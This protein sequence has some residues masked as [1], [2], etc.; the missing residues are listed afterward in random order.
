MTGTG[1]AILANRISYFYNLH[2]TSVTVDTACSSSLVCL[3]LGNQ[4]LKTGESDISIIVGSSLHFDPREYILMTDLGMLSMDGRSRAF[5]AGA[6]GYV[7]GEGICAAI[8]KRQS[9]AVRNGDHIRAI[10][11]ATGTNHDGRTQGITLPSPEAQEALIRSTYEQAGLKFEDTQY[12]EAHGTGTGAGDPRETSAI[13]AVFAATR[14]QPL[15]VGSV[16]T[17]I[18]H[19]EGSSGLAGIIKTTLALENHKI[20]P[21]ML[22]NN[23]NPKIK[24]EDWK[25]SVPTELIPWEAKNGVR[26]ASINSFGYG[27]TNAHVVLEGYH[28]HQNEDFQFGTTEEEVTDD[29]KLNGSRPYLIPLSSHATKA[30]EK[31]EKAL[32]D[33]LANND[34]IKPLDLAHSLSLRRSI[35]EQRSF[36]IGKNC[37]DLMDQ[38]AVYRPTAPWTSAN[39]TAPRLGFIFTGQGGQWY[40]MGRQLINDCAFFRQTLERCDAVLQALPDA[41]RWS[42]VAELCKSKEASLLGETEYSQPLCTALQLAIVDLLKIW[43]IEP[44]AVVGHSSGEMG[45]AY[46]AGILSFDN[47]LIAAYYRGLYM[48]APVDNSTKGGM[49]AIGLTEPEAVVELEP[50]KGRLAIAAINSPS[51]MTISGDEDAILELKAILT[52]RK[53]FARQLQVTQAF[54]SHHMY[55]LAPAYE[56]ALRSLPGFEPQPPKNIMVSS[57]TGQVA[58]YQT[59]DASYW[60]RNMTNMVKFSEALTKVLDDANGGIDALIEIGPHPALKGPSRQTVQSLKIEKPYFASLTRGVPDYEGILA[61]AGQLFSIGYPVD[62]DA[63]NQEFSILAD[64]RVSKTQKGKR[65]SDLPSYAWEHRRYWAETRYTKELRLRESRHNLLGAP[66]PGSL[67]NHKRWRNRI[68]L[69]EIPWLSEHVVDGKVIFPGAGYISMAI[70][71]A[72]QMQPVSD[73]KA[74][75]LKDIVIKAALVLPESDKGVEMVVE[76][77]PVTTSAKTRSSRWFEFL[78]CSYDVEDRC[79]EHCHGLISV[80]QGPA[81]LDVITSYPSSENLRK[82]SDRSESAASFYRRLTALGLQYGPKF[83]LLTGTLDRGAGFAISPLDFDPNSFSTEKADATILHPTLLDGSFHIGFSAIES[84]LGRQL[85]EPFVPTFISALNLSGSFAQARGSMDKGEFEICCFSKLPSSRVAISDLLLRSRVDGSP[86]MEIQGLEVTSL[87][88]E[89]T[90]ELRGRTLFFGQKWQACFDLLDN[91]VDLP[92]LHSLESLLDIYAHQHPN[93]TMLHISSDAQRTRE[94]IQN[95]GMAEGERRRIH[96]IHVHSLLPDFTPGDDFNALKESARGLLEFKEP[97]KESYDV[98]ILSESVD[99]DARLYLKDNGVLILDGESPTSVSNMKKQFSKG[100]L[101]VFRGFNEVSTPPEDLTVI[102]SPFMSSRSQG[103]FNALVTSYPGQVLPTTFQDL[104]LEPVSTDTIVV[105]SSLDQDIGDQKSFTGVQ[106]LLTSVNKN[107]VW[108]TEGA[109]M[110]SSRPDL[111]T[112]IGLLRSARSENDDL[113]AVLLDLWTRNTSQCCGLQDH[114]DS[115]YQ[116][117]GRRAHGTGRLHLYPQS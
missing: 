44:S 83:S 74:I 57:V 61:L 82:E 11:R 33:H 110:E 92:E 63:V 99:F 10:V 109:T 17:N 4:S 69:D 112:Y 77:R 62:L 18:G 35:H 114:S 59:M 65:L 9:D 24:F 2:G 117:S 67:S 88:K 6:S 89:G 115:G 53:V 85:D 97:Q 87:G 5:D 47:A 68:I 34:Q 93:A 64:G 22:F 25:I 13:G 48:S 78:V 111:A 55:P 105:L 40:A 102:I 100:N 71:G 36:V 31:F 29:T 70:E 84:C 90:D 37:D 103:I 58:D 98:V 79:T 49:M 28:D 76:L 7:R 104:S 12:F 20:P 43:G 30:G 19:L 23:P 95:L 86:L 113:R 54:H 50:F 66:V 73:I 101:S 38:L 96:N 39:K 42:V 75:C 46:A 52:K 106:N 14:E 27:G 56:A 15:Y 108:L 116:P 51:T 26:R 41:P 72:I 3:H 32:Q 8:L 94:A 80:E 91:G 21:N 16:K 1:G 107:I 60:A 45:A 81:C